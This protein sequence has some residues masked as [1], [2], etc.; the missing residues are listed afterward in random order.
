MIGLIIIINKYLSQELLTFN[1]AS[2][3]EAKDKLISVLIDKFKNLNIDFP[4]LLSDLEYLWFNEEAID[5]P[6]FSYK[7]FDDIWTNPWEEQDIY[8][9]VLD[10]LHEIEIN[11]IPDLSKLYNEPSENYSYNE[12]SE[13]HLYD[14][15]SENNIDANKNT[16]LESV[17]KNIINNS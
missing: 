1:L 17:I 4:L 7:I 8:S 12:P 6:I 13:N 14:E 15:P 10:K 9:D 5:L 11:T 16:E 3:D 2:I